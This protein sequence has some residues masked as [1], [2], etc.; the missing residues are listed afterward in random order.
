MHTKENWF[1]FLPHSVHC[2]P[3]EVTPKFKSVKCDIAQHKHIPFLTTY[4]TIYLV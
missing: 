3:V 2:V 1:V 4:V